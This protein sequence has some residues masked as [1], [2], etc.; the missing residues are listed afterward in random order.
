AGG[1][2]RFARPFR[3]FGTIVII[4]HGAGWSTLLTGLGSTGVRVGQ[5]LPAGTLVGRAGAGV[6][7]QV[8]V[9]LRRRGRPVDI[10]ALL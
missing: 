4:D 1:A 10:A 9:E 2:V 5:T 3:G 8:T 7:R 6:D